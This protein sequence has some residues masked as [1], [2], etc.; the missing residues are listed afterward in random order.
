MSA[1]MHLQ[2]RSFCNC[3]TPYSS[4]IVLES[5]T[6]TSNLKT[7]SYAIKVRL[8]SLQTSVLPRQKTSQQILD[9]VQRF[10]CHRNVTNVMVPR[11]ISRLLMISG[12]SVSSS[13]ISHADATLG[14]EQSDATLPTPPTFATLAFSNPSSPSPTNLTPSSVE[15]LNPIPEDGLPWTAYERQ[16]S[17]ALALPSALQRHRLSS[18]TKNRRHRRGAGGL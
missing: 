1:T 18:L 2:S 11:V 14:R 4:A 12:L 9:V 15:S 13:S 5:I 7:S 16:S 8:L 17:T 6:V 10:T 3:S